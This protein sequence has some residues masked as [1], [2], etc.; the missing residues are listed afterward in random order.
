M[1]FPFLSV[2][3][4]EARSPVPLY[5]YI[6]LT[7][8]LACASKAAAAA[9]SVRLPSSPPP[10]GIFTALLQIGQ[11]STRVDSGPHPACVRC[12]RQ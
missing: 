9:S 5:L 2:Y 10:L 6:I 4:L 7:L 3:L 11:T 8:L 1:S 12:S